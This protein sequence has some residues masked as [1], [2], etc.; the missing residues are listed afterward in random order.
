M[1][2][3]TGRP[4]TVEQYLAALDDARRATV[5]RMR[6]AVRA[7]VPEAR[8]AFSYRMP[9]FTVD[10][11]PLVW[12]AAWKRHFSVYPVTAEQAAAAAGPDDAYDVEKGTVRFAANAPVPY[13]FV[14]R[15]ARARADA[16][17]AGAS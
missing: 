13:D 14:G 3:G 1:P 16:L 7:A 9:G 5:E 17:A 10:G 12:V 8:D 11:R 6:D 4:E 15:L 2:G